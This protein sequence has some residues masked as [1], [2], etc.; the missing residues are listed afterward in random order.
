MSLTSVVLLCCA[1]ACPAGMGLMM[2]FMGRG[3]HGQRSHGPG[4]AEP[5]A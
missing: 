3:T 4:R 2:S 1:L 5:D